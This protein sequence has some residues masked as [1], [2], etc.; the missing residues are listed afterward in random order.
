M[1]H[2]ASA[3]PSLV[4]VSDPEA[5]TEVHRLINEQRLQDAAREALELAV[6]GREDP[7][8]LAIQAIHAASSPRAELGT[9]T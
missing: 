9:T 8:E 3:A 1:L 7:R 6:M 5:D 4:G 2:S